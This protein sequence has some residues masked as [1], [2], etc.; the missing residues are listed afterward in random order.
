LYF[1]QNGQTRQSGFLPFVF[2]Q[3]FCPQFR[4]Q[5]NQLHLHSFFPLLTFSPSSLRK[6]AV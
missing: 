1:V 6:K 4:G 3:S 5:T 2:E